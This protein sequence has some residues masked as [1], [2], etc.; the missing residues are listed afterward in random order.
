MLKLL[1]IY[2]DDDDTKCL[3]KQI[4]RFDGADSCEAFLAFAV[5][6]L[7]TVD[8]AYRRLIVVNV[9][10]MATAVAAAAEMKLKNPYTNKCKYIKD[11]IIQ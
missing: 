10:T 8:S 4:G 1:G 2:D 7:V 9:M 11:T 6:R 3:W 5:A